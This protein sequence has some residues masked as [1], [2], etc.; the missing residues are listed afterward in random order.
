MAVGVVPHPRYIGRELLPLA[1][2]FL[3]VGISTAVVE[4][5]R[6]LFL[7]TAV[8][9]DPVQLTV[10]LIVTPLAGV[11]A[12][13]LIGRLSDRRA[14]RRGLLIGT[15][16]AGL[17]GMGL[18]AFVR[19]YW[20]LLALTATAT[21]LAGALFPQTFAYA[22]QLLAH[23]G[24][25]PAMGIST[26]RTVFSLA[27]VAGPPLAAVLLDAGGFAYI[28]GTAAAMYATAALVAI[29]WLDKLDTPTAP[30]DSP[31]DEPLPDLAGTPAASR[32][33]LLLTAAA[34]TILV[35]PLT[36]CVQALPLFI[37]TDLG[38]D[39]TDA[40][41]I[42]GLCAALEI[43]LMLGLGILATRIRVRALVLAGACCG[44]AYHALAAVASTIWVLAAAQ[45]LNAVFIAAVAGLGITYMQD[46]LPLQPGRATTL[47]TNSFPI[48]AILA[49]PLFGLAQH[50]G[51]RSA[52]VVGAALCSAGLL[53]L[54]ITRPSGSASSI[55]R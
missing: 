20:F 40:G 33:T 52:Y 32:S 18:T 53:A 37:S 44:V 24:S 50:L 9:A 21:A 41:L 5:F 28:F 42:L 45:I 48:G 38:G 14:I 19:D 3:A 16:V 23:K 27:W 39:A 55:P 36:L 31:D 54:L 17:I 7:S 29:F 1:L 8:R 12:S 15:S 22:R 49:G 25:N 46:M 2:V 34:F 13:T 51:Y 30:T 11:I 26:L 4:P 6:S 47:F 10:F 43:P 35:C